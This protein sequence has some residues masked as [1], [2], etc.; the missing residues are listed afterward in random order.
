MDCIVLFE[1]VGGC[2]GSI[3]SSVTGTGVT[4]GTGLGF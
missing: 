4:G 3:G 1:T 2:G